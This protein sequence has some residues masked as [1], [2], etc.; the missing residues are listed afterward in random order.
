LTDARW[1]RVF[2]VGFVVLDSIHALDHLRQGRVLAPQIYA[3]GTT[4]LIGSIVV[5]V[6][7]MRQQRVAS[8]A[9][10]VFGTAA[11]LG[12]FAAHI[13]PNW[14]YLSDSYQPLHLDQLSWIIAIAVILDAAAL[15]LVGVS[16][17]RAPAEHLR[18]T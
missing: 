12:V 15:A 4:V 8:L 16:M 11:A 13:M 6:L 1:L 10:T 9:A 3:G 2:A 14:F 17:L 18:G 5:A 7:V